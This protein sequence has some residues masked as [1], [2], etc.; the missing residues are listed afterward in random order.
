MQVYCR[1]RMGTLISVLSENS[2]GVCSTAALTL[3]IWRLIHMPNSLQH[4]IGADE[5]ADRPKVAH[6]TPDL[7]DQRADR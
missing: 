2:M 1:F 3:H 4:P 6:I 5:T 7:A